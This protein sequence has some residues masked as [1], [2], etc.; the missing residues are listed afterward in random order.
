M[1]H[2][3]QDGTRGTGGQVSEFA[4]RSYG[5]RQRAQLLFSFIISK[6]ATASSLTWH[7]KT[8]SAAFS[9]FQTT[10]A[11]PF[12]A[13]CFHLQKKPINERIDCSGTRMGRVF[14]IRCTRALE[15]VPFSQT[16]SVWSDVATKQPNPS[17]APECARHFTVHAQPQPNRAAPH[18]HKKWIKII[19][20]QQAQATSS[21]FK[22][23]FT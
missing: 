22:P 3:T 8:L 18:Q 1:Q 16:W 15:A 19:F 14:E 20:T 21:F 2:T 10:K 17:R 7:C 9:S 12:L 6:H 11:V 5:C 23:T 4:N 13:D